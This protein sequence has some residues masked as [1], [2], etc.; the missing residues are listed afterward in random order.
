[1]VKLACAWIEPQPSSFVI[2]QTIRMGTT[3]AGGEIRY[4]TD[5]GVPTAASPRYD[6]PFTIDKTTSIRAAVFC[7]DSRL[8]E[9]LVADLTR[10]P[11]SAPKISAGSRTFS[12]S[13]EVSLALPPSAPG[14][15]I[16]YTLDGTARGGR[17][18]RAT[19]RRCGS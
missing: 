5:G 2:S 9:V 6:K 8:T 17:A 14:A 15:E 10:L 4:T 18:R 3:L 19:R 12:K 7:G 11:M 1:M 16:H 13:T